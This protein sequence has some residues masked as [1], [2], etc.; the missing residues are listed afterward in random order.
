MKVH[1]GIDADSGLVHTVVGAVLDKLGHFKTKVEHP[2][3]VIKRQSGFVKVCYRGLMRNAA[4]L[5]ILFVLSSI[6]TR[7]A[8]SRRDVHSSVGFSASALNTTLK[9]CHRVENVSANGRALPA[10]NV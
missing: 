5:Q 2:F 4:Q 8:V 3:R 9:F 7:T 6:E 1:I 10:F